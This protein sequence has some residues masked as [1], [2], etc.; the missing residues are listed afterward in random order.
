MR[1]ETV[2]ALMEKLDGQPVVV[3]IKP[4]VALGFASGSDGRATD[5][6]VHFEGMLGKNPEIEELWFVAQAEQP[7]PAPLPP[8]PAKACYFNA[9]DVGVI[10]EIYEDPAPTQRLIQ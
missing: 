4:A 7:R 2:E 8:E 6:P 3:Y 1:K 9:E 5:G 10:V